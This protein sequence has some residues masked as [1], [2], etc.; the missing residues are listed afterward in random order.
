MRNR[1]PRVRQRAAAVCTLSLALLGPP[2]AHGEQGR[3]V[4]V[5]NQPGCF[6]WNPN[7]QPDEAVWWS[8][9]CFEGKA[10]GRGKV[11]VIRQDG[12]T[13]SAEGGHIKG[14]R[15]GRWVLRDEAGSV[16]EGFYAENNP[17]GAWVER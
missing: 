16:S 7:P 15:N 5:E 14:N 13:T 4:E 1:F 6:L 11:T 3:Y 17:V 10:E 2:S 8:G 9:E 12:S